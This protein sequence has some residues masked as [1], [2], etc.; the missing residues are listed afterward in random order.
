[1]LFLYWIQ[2]SLMVSECHDT[3]TRLLKTI[4]FLRFA[5]YCHTSSHPYIM[6]WVFTLRLYGQKYWHLL[7]QLL[8][9]V[10]WGE[11]LWYIQSIMTW[12]Q[13]LCYYDIAQTYTVHVPLSTKKSSMYQCKYLKKYFFWSEK[14][15]RCFLLRKQRPPLWVL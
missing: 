5:I 14:E 8:Y 7:F 1:M 3:N 12:P 2:W 6:N 13:K 4:R 15:R 9:R 11:M 10:F